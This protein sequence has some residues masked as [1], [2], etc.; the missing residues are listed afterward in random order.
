VSGHRLA[1]TGNYVEVGFD[2]RT[3]TGTRVARVRITGVD[4]ERTEGRLAS[5]DTATRSVA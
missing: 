5:L 2:A 3:H 4:G 1:L